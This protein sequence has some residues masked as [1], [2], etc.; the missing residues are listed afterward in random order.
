MD[1]T[2]TE[3]RGRSTH[4]R[5][6]GSE[7]PGGGSDESEH[8]AGPTGTAD[9]TGPRDGRD[10]RWEQH[11]G[12]RRTTLVDAVIQAIRI[13]GAGVGM[14]E[15]AATAGTSKTVIYRY[16]DDK[17]G[18]YRAVADRIDQR[19]LRHVGAALAQSSAPDG[20]PRQLISS[21]VDAYLALVE[22]DTEVYRFVV[23]RPLVDRPLVNDPV[24]GT[25]TQAAGLL[26]AALRAGGVEP[27]LARFWA[28]A[29]VGSV[30]A[31]A[32]DWLNDPAR[33]PRHEIVATLTDLAWTGLAPALQRDEGSGVDDGRQ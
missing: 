9:P 24:D 33:L 17:A 8:P 22:S 14:D 30:Q 21:T 18:V 4:G 28:I 15:I 7:R 1:N 11:R 25:I 31:V 13:H 32:H 10:V 19:V 23:G 12:E 2:E 29:L 5:S 3:P 16:F 6:G 27:A 20:D 26:Q